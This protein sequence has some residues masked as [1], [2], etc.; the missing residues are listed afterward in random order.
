MT[1]HRR[2]EGGATPTLADIAGA[3]SAENS[4]PYMGAKTKTKASSCDDHQQITP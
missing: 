2:P 1:H 3:V 4:P